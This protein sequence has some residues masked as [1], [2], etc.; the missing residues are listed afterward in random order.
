[1]I[2]DSFHSTLQGYVD[3][4][5]SGTIIT[6][7][8]VRGAVERFE[9]DLARQST[10][11][12]PYHFDET[13][14]A[15]VC[16]FY[17]SVIRHSIGRYAG[18][19]FELEPWQI[20]CV[21]NIFGWLMDADRTRRF[22][23]TYRS[24]ARKNGK[25]T[26]IAAESIYMAGFDRNP[27]RDCVEPVSQVVLSASKRD[28][29]DKVVFA[30][31]KR[32]R[33]KSQAL[34]K[35][36]DFIRKEI[37]FPA[38]DGEIITTGS[39]KPYDGLNPHAVG[40]DELHAWREHHREFYDTMVTGSGFRDQP[41][42]SI[43]TTAG[44]DRSHLWREVYEY[45]KAVALGVNSDETFFSYIAELDEGD[46][47]F[48]E[49][50]WIKANPNLGVSVSL[51]YL[52]QQ[53][54]EAKASAVGTNRFTRYHGNRLVTSTEKAFDLDA[55][56]RCEGV[57]GDWEDADAV[58][59]GVDLGARDDLAASAQVARFVIGERD[60]MPVYRYEVRVKAY[61]SEETERDLTKAPFFQWIYDGLL[62]KSRFP[63]ADLRDFLVEKCRNFDASTVAYDPY[64][65]QSLAEELT[66]EGLTPLRMAQNHSMFNEPIRDFMA[67]VNE[68]R[69]AHDGNPLLRWCVNN[70]VLYRDRKDLW[71][72]DKKSS[73]E[74]IDPIVAV[75]MAFR[76][77]CLAPSRASGS[78]FYT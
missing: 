76:V 78:L 7:K 19:P 53:A 33:L 69:V 26:W 3:G 71:M 77:C 44:D 48:D 40:M 57:V 20:F 43:I 24:M 51:D 28:Q 13:L 63:I 50:L 34:A 31:I 42:I 49:S 2:A 27:L 52:R 12:F 18:M 74:K 72:F 22:R 66:R 32:M 1:V 60:G 58:G 14:A 8:S 65:A 23:K 41:L 46:D 15:K 5:L 47:P 6:S 45:A 61:I 38:N 36:S 10:S 4:V 75:V 70:A 54:T 68:G 59:A 37:R 25:S 30:E 64:N 73:A 55:W 16:R 9:R 56:D 67:A 39:D 29:V 35:R 11:D 62:E 17:P 21:A